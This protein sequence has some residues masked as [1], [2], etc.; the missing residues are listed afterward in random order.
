LGSLKNVSQV[1]L[2]AN[3][4]LTSARIDFSLDNVIWWRAKIVSPTNGQWNYNSP[5][6]TARYVRIVQLTGATWTMKEIEIRGDTYAR[7]TPA[8]LP[9]TFQQSTASIQDGAYA[10][11]G[12]LST[13]A[14]M[15]FC[16]CNSNAFVQFD[17]GAIANIMQVH[18]YNIPDARA[19]NPANTLFSGRIDYSVDGTNWWTAG[20]TPTPT[21]GIAQW[22]SFSLPFV[23]RYVRLQN[24]SGSPWSLGEVEIY[25]TTYSP[26]IPSGLVATVTASANIRDLGYARDANL[27]TRGY[28]HFCPCDGQYIKLDLGSVQLVTKVRFYSLPDNWQA[29]TSTNNVFTGRIES[30]TNGTTWTTAATITGVVN[31]WIEVNLILSARYIR[32]YHTS[33]PTGFSI[34]EVEV[35][36]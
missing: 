3:T 23:A 2:L 19:D 27:N 7:G 18:Y 13:R 36:P 11:D 22:Q 29:S 5:S 9:T 24:L 4:G 21:A 32:L 35:Y 33:R 28:V 30:S 20:T 1:N 25:G 6:F 26:G 31:Q 17:L 12:N 14:Y 10:N 34:A 15:Q 16:G 8:G